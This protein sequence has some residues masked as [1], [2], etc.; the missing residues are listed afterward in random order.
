MGA[1]ENEVDA[2]NEFDMSKSNSSPASV[3]S[4]EL[5]GAVVFGTLY[6]L[7][8]LSSLSA[9]PVVITST[10]PERDAVL[11][12]TAPSRGVEPVLP[13]ALGLTGKSSNSK[14]LSRIDFIVRDTL[15]A[16]CIA[17]GFGGMVAAGKSA[18]TSVGLAGVDATG[19][20]D[21]GANDCPRPLG[22]G[23]GRRL[24]VSASSRTGLRGCISGAVCTLSL[25]LR[26]TVLATI[27]GGRAALGGA[28]VRDALEAMPCSMLPCLFSFSAETGD[29]CAGICSSK[30]HCFEA[31][32]LY[33][34]LGRGDSG[35]NS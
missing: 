11:T 26:G 21:A 34:L 6:L 18:G 19:L 15:I 1:L 12:T 35:A 14:S 7:Y 25:V 23:N 16:A 33:A 9:P 28:A 30:C 3:V 24:I 32:A 4:V 20:G 27:L 17:G 2:F 8:L 5:G 22:D 10:L 31:G 13:V 29:D